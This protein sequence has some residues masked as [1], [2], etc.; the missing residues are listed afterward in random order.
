MFFKNAL[1]GLLIYFLVSTTIHPWY[2]LNLLFLSLFTKYKFILIW[3][4][5]IVL[6]YFAYSQKSFQENMLLIFLEYATFLG[7]LGYEIYR[8][9]K[10]V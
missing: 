9:K 10:K 1:F 5:T 7:F 3:T 4:F 2:V 8:M 6:S